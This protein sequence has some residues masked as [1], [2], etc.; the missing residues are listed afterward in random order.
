MR[1]KRELDIEKLSVNI[2]NSIKGVSKKDIESTIEKHNSLPIYKVSGEIKR[3]T[4]RINENTMKEFNDLWRRKFSQYK[5][6]DLL[7]LALQMFIDEY[8]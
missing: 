5:Q 6:H 8:K 2:L 1:E 3:T 4:I 7:N